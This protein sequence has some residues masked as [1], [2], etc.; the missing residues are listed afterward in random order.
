MSEFNKKK[1][2]KE[3]EEIEIQIKDRLIDFGRE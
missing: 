1:S 2:D 3:E